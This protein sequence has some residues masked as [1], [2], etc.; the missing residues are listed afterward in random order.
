MLFHLPL[1]ARDTMDVES[2]ASYTYRLSYEHGFSVGEFL[3]LM[4]GHAK[5]QGSMPSKMKL[6]H[7]IQPGDLVKPLKTTLLVKHLLELYSD[8][9][10]DSSYLWIFKRSKLSSTG[11]VSKGFRWCPECF[12]EMSRTKAGAYFKLIWSMSSI[13]LCPTHLTPLIELCPRCNSQQNT[14]VR[15]R[16][17][18]ECQE[19]GHL[20]SD[21]IIKLDL[22]SINK[23]DVNRGNDV[24]GMFRRLNEIPHK[25]F[26]RDGVY[27]SVKGLID[28]YASNEREDELFGSLSRDELLSIAYRNKGRSFKLARRVA[29]RLGIPLYDYLAGRAK[30]ITLPLDGQL[31]CKLPSGFLETARRTQK[32]H[33]KILEQVES[34][35][36]QQSTP[37]SIRK[38]AEEVGV[39]SGYLEYRHPALVSD[40]VEKRENFLKRQK[41]E[42]QYLATREALSYFLGEK[43]ECDVRSKRGAFRALREHTTLPKRY[44]NY[45]IDKA[46]KAL[47][48]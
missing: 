38:I 25:D 32:N 40:L 27:L 1:L 16:P 23:A 13:T 3:N 20:L 34:Y 39:T 29:F 9:E 24:V 5:K 42:Y 17:L 45:G 46:Y 37:P 43:Y 35:I 36:L 11:E 6:Q 7:N 22:Q 28:Y 26:P 18:I 14:K 8:I 44:I 10:I 30:D 4:Y 19:C 31:F 48:S 15:I 2:L 47:Y 33:K 21:R 41:L 12:R